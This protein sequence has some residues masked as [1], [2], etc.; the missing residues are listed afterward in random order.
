[1][2]ELYL[3]PEVQCFPTWIDRNGT[4]EN[5]APSTLPISSGLAQDV[6]LW[7][8]RWDAIYDLADPANPVFPSQEAE[9]QFRADGS[10]LLAR[11]RYELG[12]EW[13]VTLHI[14]D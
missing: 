4:R 5:V 14:P 8:Q 11:L 7:G 9:Q 12:Y 6:D 13:E 3:I 1:M 10:A 2:Q